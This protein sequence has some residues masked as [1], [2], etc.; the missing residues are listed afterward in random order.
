MFFPIE[1]CDADTFPASSSCTASSMNEWLCI[2]GRFQLNDQTNIFDIQPSRCDISCNQNFSLAVSERV[3][4][5]L[6]FFLIHVPL[7]K[8]SLLTKFQCNISHFELC[9]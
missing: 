8:G 6:S 1:Q 5:K 3:Q 2:S 9:L 7:Q 4:I